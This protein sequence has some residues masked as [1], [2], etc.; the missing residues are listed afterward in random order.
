MNPNIDQFEIT[1]LHGQKTISIP[2]KDNRIVLVGV[3]G[4]GK[5]TV[6]TLLYLMLS[7]QWKR[8]L[9]YN[10][11]EL[12]IVLDGQRIRLPR[13]Q[14]R[15]T[16]NEER[17]LKVFSS[18]LSPTL[19]SRLL[20]EAGISWAQQVMDVVTEPQGLYRFLWSR[21]IRVPVSVLDKM[22]NELQAEVAPF[23]NVALQEADTI[24]KERL[25]DYQIL[26]L[27][28]YRRI[29]KDLQTIFPDLEEHIQTFN[30]RRTMESR[31]EP[32]SYIELVEFGMED[33]ESTF[34]R[35]LNELNETARETLN[36]LTGSYLRDVIR[37]E[38][39]TYDPTVFHALD[40]GTVQSILNRVEE[41]TLSEADKSSLRVVID[42]I[43]RTPTSVTAEDK[44]I[45]HF[46]AKL[47]AAHKTLIEKEE[48]ASHFARVCNQ[49]LRGKA[50]IYD[51]RTYR[52]SVALV[53]S[54]Q[55]IP[56]RELSSGEKQIVSL[57]SHLYLQRDRSVFVLIDE[58]E[59]SLSVEWQKM[60]L[61]DI[62]DS[63]RC[64]F[65]AAVTHSPFVF[66]NE[67]DSYAN[68][69]GEF[70]RSNTK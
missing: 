1:N 9:E 52:I 48:S 66:D 67:L 21:G 30:R 63:Q 62:L 40:E 32:R 59:L 19:F 50:V 58:P 33:V 69:L 20:A 15:K 37:R 3:N 49:Y 10:F 17:V 57:F 6:I 26:F 18:H 12:A 16:P 42:K 60:L 68:D 27:P 41:R 13:S 46:F 14:T 7:R 47:V 29:E 24:I 43:K 25:S 36:S 23:D 65:L 44:Y 61:P 34:R 51:D 4:L 54:G 5:T 35:T 39:N 56:L 38:G 53:P 55:H 64:F 2:I 31:G 45:A 22:Q 11:S 28:T 70:V 8:M